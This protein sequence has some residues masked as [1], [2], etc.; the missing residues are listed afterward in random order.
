MYNSSFFRSLHFSFLS[1]R[2]LLTLYTLVA[3][4]LGFS[5]FFIIHYALLFLC[6]PLVWFGL[7][8]PTLLSL[9][10]GVGAS[11]STWQTYLKTAA[12]VAVADQRLIV[13][14]QLKVCSPAQVPVQVL[15]TWVKGGQ[16]QGLPQPS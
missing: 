14:P 15:P 10:V 1:L 12:I 2:L 9:V 16:D 13:L 3:G 8:L 6:A 4:F 11:G 7:N 5:Y